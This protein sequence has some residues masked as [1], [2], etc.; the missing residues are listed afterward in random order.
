MRGLAIRK[1]N[2]TKISD[3]WPEFIPQLKNKF[4]RFYSNN[5]YWRLIQRKEIDIKDYEFRSD[6]N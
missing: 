3:A 2:F 4:W 5:I 1:E 6:F